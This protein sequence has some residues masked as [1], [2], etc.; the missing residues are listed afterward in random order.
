MGR[1]GRGRG[2]KPPAYGLSGNGRSRCC[3]FSKTRLNKRRNPRPS[4]CIRVL[5]P[6]KFY[7]R[8]RSHRPP[9][10]R[11]P[12]ISADAHIQ[13]HRRP[14][15]HQSPAQGHAEELGQGESDNPDGQCLGQEHEAR[16]ARA[17]RPPER[18]K[19]Q[20][21]AGSISAHPQTAHS[22]GMTSGPDVKK[23]TRGSAKR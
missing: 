13:N 19:Y 23:R 17:R 8:I 20:A 22:C 12:S 7:T 10:K 2:A 9:R 11:R 6:I 16:V 1:G 3:S 15:P 21:S 5:F 14:Y 4:A 18:T